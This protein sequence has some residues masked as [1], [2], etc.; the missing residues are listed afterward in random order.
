L[1]TIT[2][3]H[4]F[5]N[6]KKING[7][8]INPGTNFIHLRFEDNGIGFDP[9]KLTDRNGIVNMKM[10]AAKLNG[11]LDIRSTVGKGTILKLEFYA[12]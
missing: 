1:P 4:E 3:T 8:A 5:L 6:G 12:A 7:T 11:S 2:I 9:Q 10:R